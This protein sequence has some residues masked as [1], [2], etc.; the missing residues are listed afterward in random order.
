MNLVN[1]RLSL[2]YESGELQIEFECMNLVNCR[3]S[4]MYESGELQ[5]EFN[6]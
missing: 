5:I 3:L 6:V 2:M 4:L 1:C